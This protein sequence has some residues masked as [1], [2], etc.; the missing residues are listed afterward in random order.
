[1]SQTIQRRI[2]G[3]IVAIVVVITCA[4]LGRW[5]W[6]RHHERAEAVDQVVSNY[7]RT[8]VEFTELITSPDEKVPQTFAW[9]PV[10]LHGEFIEPTVKIRNRPI[11]G[12]HGYHVA[13]PFE[14]SDASGL[15]VLINRG[16]VT[17]NSDPDLE[18]ANEGEVTIIGH[19]RLAEAPDT[20]EAPVGHGFTFNPHQLLPE[21]DNLVAN[22]YVMLSS[23]TPPG[24]SDV[25]PLPPPDTDL[26]SHLSYAFQWWIFAAGAVVAY[27]ILLRREDQHEGAGKVRARRRDDDEEDA[28]IA[29]WEEERDA[30]P[31][32]QNH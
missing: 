18:I 16:F 32:N 20:R 28:L 24:P 25:V 1:M 11:D 29:A 5:Q 8:P 13:Q 4:F 3:A 17:T 2:I 14:L 6:N 12:K 31:E 9:R 26:G 22:A 15:T 23:Q 21:T 30:L 27:F 7:E 19:V 10:V